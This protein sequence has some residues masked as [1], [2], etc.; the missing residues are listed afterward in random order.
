MYKIPVNIKAGSGA[1]HGNN[2]FAAF[3]AFIYGLCIY[4]LMQYLF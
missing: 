1:Y 3:I 4:E 2:N